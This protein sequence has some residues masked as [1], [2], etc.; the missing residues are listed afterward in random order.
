MALVGRRIRHRDDGVLLGVDR[1]AG[2]EGN[3]VRVNAEAVAL[4]ALLR[5][6][7][8][9]G[10]SFDEIQGDSRTGALPAARS[11][12]AY[13]LRKRG[14]SY[15]EIAKYFGWR[16]HTSAICAVRKFA[17]RLSSKSK[18]EV[19]YAR[20]VVISNMLADEQAA[21]VRTRAE[22]AA[23]KTVLRGLGGEQ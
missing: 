17:L 23:L 4:Q 12:A 1:L 7:Y 19:C 2:D 8:F 14:M 5:A 13:E 16:T 20:E 21:H 3:G 15:P 22:L 11:A 6:A 10:V 18:A 9:Y